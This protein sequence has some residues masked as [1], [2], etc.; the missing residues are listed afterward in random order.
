MLQRGE[1]GG[2]DDWLTQ[3]L[4]NNMCFA[5]EYTLEF[6]KQQVS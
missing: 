5:L 6:A 1:P 3:V 2:F 4:W